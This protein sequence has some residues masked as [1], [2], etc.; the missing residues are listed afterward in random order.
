TTF[1]LR[2]RSPI[3]GFKSDRTPLAT[4]PLRIHSSTALKKSSYSEQRIL[5]IFHYYGYLL[6]LISISHD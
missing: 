2:T 1:P 3:L 6:R 4:F 5:H